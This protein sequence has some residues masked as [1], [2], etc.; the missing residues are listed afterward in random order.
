MNGCIRMSRPGSI[1]GKNLGGFFDFL[2]PS[3]WNLNPSYSPIFQSVVKPAMDVGGAFVGL[4]GAGSL[5]EAGANALEGKQGAPTSAP[6]PTG[7]PT[8][9]PQT[10][11][12]ATTAAPAPAEKDNTLLYVGVGIGGVVLLGGVIYLA[13]KK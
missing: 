9:I 10:T 6:A 4:P 7:S 3:T 2:D 1:R 11:A 13:T 12:M 8:M 5:L